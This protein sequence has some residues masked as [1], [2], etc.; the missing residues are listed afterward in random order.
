MLRDVDIGF[1]DDGYLAIRIAE[2]NKG[3]CKQMVLSKP[4]Y[5]H[6]EGTNTDKRVLNRSTARR[7][8]RLEFCER[9]RSSCG[10]NLE[11]DTAG[12]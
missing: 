7:R 5:L 1:Q 6:Y 8:P 10:R 2:A 9:I 4:V 12:T 11:P 3:F